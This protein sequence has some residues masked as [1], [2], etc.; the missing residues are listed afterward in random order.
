MNALKFGD[1]ELGPKQGY[2]RAGDPNFEA[3]KL[4]VVCFLGI[5]NRSFRKAE[6]WSLV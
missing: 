3:L 5:D 2:T 4:E 1:S 6:A